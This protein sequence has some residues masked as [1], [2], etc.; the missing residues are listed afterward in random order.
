MFSSLSHSCNTNLHVP[1]VTPSTPHND[2]STNTT[3]TTTTSLSIPHSN[4]DQHHSSML[5]DNPEEDGWLSK[6]QVTEWSKILFKCIK[7]IGDPEFRITDNIATHTITLKID[8]TAID[9]RHAESVCTQEQVEKY[10]QLGMRREEIAEVALKLNAIKHLG[11]N[12][13]ID[14]LFD[15]HG[16][17]IVDGNESNEEREDAVYFVEEGKNSV[18]GKEKLLVEEMN[19]SGLVNLQRE[20]D[21]VIYRE[22]SEVGEGRET[23]LLQ[24]MTMKIRFMKSVSDEEMKTRLMSDSEQ[25]MFESCDQV[26]MKLTQLELNTMRLMCGNKSLASNLGIRKRRTNDSSSSEERFVHTD[27][28][29]PFVGLLLEQGKQAEQ[30][31]KEKE[32]LKALASIDRANEQ[33]SSSCPQQLEERETDKIVMKIPEQV[34]GKESTGIMKSSGVCIPNPNQSCQCFA[35]IGAVA[36]QITEVRVH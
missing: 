3:T 1:T 19:R 29:Q 7:P 6:E 13:R 16:F 18:K 4:T 20:K 30:M 14:D 35:C 23:D 2:S 36:A 10:E 28:H 15:E 25:V 9:L 12:L 34:T 21:N 17:V 11:I 27:T 33:D 32:E 31:K 8:M 5:L 22:R 24:S 26:Q